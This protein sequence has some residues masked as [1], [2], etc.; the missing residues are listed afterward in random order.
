M[1][2]ILHLYPRWE[3][4]PNRRNRNPK[5]YPLDYRGIILAVSRNQNAKITNKWQ[6]KNFW[7]IFRIKILFV[8][9][10]VISRLI[11]EPIIFG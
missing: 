2:I 6:N 10:N 1:I 4:N 11:K 7:Q 8:S 3:S 5:F 9:K